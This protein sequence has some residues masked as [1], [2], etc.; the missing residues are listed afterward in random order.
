MTHALRQDGGVEPTTADTENVFF[1]FKQPSDTAIGEVFNW[2]V[3][4]VEYFCFSVFHRPPYHTV[5]I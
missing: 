1:I 5:P 2:F 4:K 3:E